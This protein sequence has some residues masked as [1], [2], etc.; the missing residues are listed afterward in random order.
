MYITDNEFTKQKYII[1]NLELTFQYKPSN[2]TNYLK[3]LRT[4]RVRYKCKY[5]N[6]LRSLLYGNI[7]KQ[8]KMAPNK[9]MFT[10]T[11]SYILW[12]ISVSRK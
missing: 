11:T 1:Q 5:I 2:Q 8:S 4:E 7:S 3:N 6:V 10:S 9:Y 12:L